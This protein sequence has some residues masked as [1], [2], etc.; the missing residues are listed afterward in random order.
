MGQR[1]NESSITEQKESPGSP[2]ASPN[3]ITSGAKGRPKSSLPKGVAP[4]RP[5]PGGIPEAVPHPR[6]MSSLKEQ[7]K[8][9]ER[10]VLLTLGSHVKSGVGA[11]GSYLPCP[12]AGSVG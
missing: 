9:G 2:K 8:E 10:R 12:G 3:A 6:F 4:C 1:L 11:G 5:G 7:M